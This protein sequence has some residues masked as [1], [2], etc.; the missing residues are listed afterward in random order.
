MSIL[1]S[2]SKEDGLFKNRLD[3]LMEILEPETDRLPKKSDR[4]YFDGPISFLIGKEPRIS[5]IHPKFMYLEQKWAAYYIKLD[6]FKNII[7][8]A[9][10]RTKITQHMAKLAHSLGEDALLIKY[11]IGGFQR[12]SVEQTIVQEQPQ[13]KKKGWLW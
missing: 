2:E 13:Q 4:D 1:L 8:P 5:N 6:Y 12:Q 9:Y 7:D 10:T 3:Q 11:G